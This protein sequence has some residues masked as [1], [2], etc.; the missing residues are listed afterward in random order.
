MPDLRQDAAELCSHAGA[1]VSAMLLRMLECCDERTA[2]L[3]RP[4]ASVL[5]KGINASQERLVD[6]GASTSVLSPALSPSVI[7]P[8]RPVRPEGAWRLLR[9]A[10]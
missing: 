10:Q 3:G 8:L 6:P 9:R 7:W 1:S 5:A 4:I 2:E